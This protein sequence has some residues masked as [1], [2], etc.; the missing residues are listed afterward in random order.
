[1]VDGLIRLMLSDYDMPVNLGSENE[2]SIIELAKT[3]IEITIQIK[4]SSS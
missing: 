2:I 3:I 1:M 4:N